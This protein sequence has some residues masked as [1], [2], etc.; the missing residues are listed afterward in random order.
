MKFR[1]RVR[2]QNSSNQSSKHSRFDLVTNPFG[3]VDLQSQTKSNLN[4]FHLDNNAETLPLEESKDENEALIHPVIAINTRD[5]K[6]SD[7][8]EEFIDEKL[9]EISKKTIEKFATSLVNSNGTISSRKRSRVLESED[10]QS[11]FREISNFPSFNV[12]SSSEPAKSSETHSQEVH[13]VESKTSSVRVVVTRAFKTSVPTIPGTVVSEDLSE[14]DLKS[15]IPA[16]GNKKFSSKYKAPER[17]SNVCSEIIKEGCQ[18]SSIPINSFSAND[19]TSSEETSDSQGETATELN[20][21]HEGPPL[22][23][24]DTENDDVTESSPLLVQNDDSTTLETTSNELNANHSAASFQDKVKQIREIL[25]QIEHGDDSEY[26]IEDGDYEYVDNEDLSAQLK[27][28]SMFDQKFGGGDTK[29]EASSSPFYRT[30]PAWNSQSN[31]SAINTQTKLVNSED[32]D[33]TPVPTNIAPLQEIV[34]LSEIKDIERPNGL[35]PY[36]FDTRENNSTAYHMRDFVRPRINVS[37]SSRSYLETSGSGTRL[38]P[39]PF[40]KSKV[41]HRETGGLHEIKLDETKQDGHDTRSGT[42]RQIISKAESVKP[43]KQ[44]GVEPI[45]LRSANQNLMKAAESLFIKDLRRHRT[46][47]H[48]KTTNTNSST[49][50]ENVTSSTKLVPSSTKTKNQAQAADQEKDKS[51]SSLNQVQLTDQG[52]DKSKSILNQNQVIDQEK[53]KS[54]SNLNH[55]QVIDQEKDKPKSNFNQAQLTELESKSNM[56]QSHVTD[57]DKDKSKSTLKSDSPDDTPVDQIPEMVN[58]FLYNYEENNTI[59]DNLIDE[60]PINPPLFLDEGIQAELPKGGGFQHFSSNDLDSE[61]FTSSFSNAQVKMYELYRDQQYLLNPGSVNDSTN[62]T[63]SP[64]TAAAMP[65]V[66]FQ[67][68]ESRCFTGN[69]EGLCFTSDMCIRKG[70]Q[71]GSNCNF[72]GLYCCTFTYTCRGVSKERVTYF[73]SPH[74]PARPSTGLT[75][76]YDVTIRPDVCAVRIEFEKVNLARKLG[77]VC[78]IDQ[79]FILNSLDGPTTGQCGPLSGYA[80]TVAVKGTQ[81]KPLKLALLIQSATPFY[82]YIKVIQLS[83]SH[84]KNFR[85][86]ARCGRSAPRTFDQNSIKPYQRKWHRVGRK[87]RQNPGQERNKKAWWRYPE[88]ILNTYYFSST[89]KMLQQSHQGP[90]RQPRRRIIS[91]SEAEIGEFPWQVAVALDGMFF[92]GGAL[93]NEHFVLTAAHCIMTRDS[94]IGDLVLHLGDHDLTQL[95]ET[96]H[97]RRGVRRVLFHSHFHPFILSN[98]IALLQLDRPVVFTETIQPVCLPHRGESFIGKRGY[99]VGWGVT[100]FPMGEPSPTLQKLEVKVLS[101]ARCST[102]IEESIGIGMMCAAPDDTQGTCFVSLI[103][104]CFVNTNP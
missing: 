93:L 49:K 9:K 3:A 101:N 86:P 67:Y 92:C 42:E 2:T 62:A 82:W 56:N 38:A 18:Q 36:G 103:P 8:E 30:L 6:I 59:S 53:Y 60:E 35:N 72:Q 69:K 4:S 99:V 27:Y 75:C 17:N 54:K 68:Q 25:E 34:V 16:Q 65:L 64:P 28:L 104:A 89:K 76:D 58:T 52:Q 45:S 29:V 94:P 85:A 23:I 31:S 47:N 40:S 96:S 66:A 21:S 44:S 12:K 32:D 78:D 73:K 13:Q 84:V 81:L 50:H 33:Q 98:D 63:T 19:R 97:V 26:V 74:H 70:G 57:E 41:Y 77:G 46:L 61:K 83:C 15:E 7:A 91:G 22:V 95:N 37:S 79:L 55:S 1:E 100:S 10:P 87:S 11:L 51:K 48:E 43:E 102:V 24:N 90:P 71:I 20:I 39:A 80:T 88:P 14:T 5:S